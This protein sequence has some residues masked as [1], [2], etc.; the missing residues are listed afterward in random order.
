MGYHL[1]LPISSS[2]FLKQLDE[3][4]IAYKHFTHEPLI[5]VKE[6]KLIQEK[7]FGDHKENGHIKNLYL[8]D[9]RKNNILLV[10]HQ[11]AIIDLKSLA[12]KIK[13]G[14]L[15]F[16]SQER[17]MENLGVLPGAVSPFAMIN[18]VKNNVTIFLDRNLKSYK[19][20][21]AHPLENNHT[22]EITFD[23]LEKF[24]KK[25]CVSPIWIDL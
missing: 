4:K 5:S 2:Q 8:R 23:Q 12:E 16:G 15:S 25:I 19:K 24:F 17:L 20:I 22:L 13:M 3:W 9:K 18:G 14:R 7:L 10:A 1:E 11:D 21:F 6:S